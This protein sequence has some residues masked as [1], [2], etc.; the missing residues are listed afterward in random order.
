M[1]QISLPGYDLRAGKPLPVIRLLPTVADP[2]GIEILD[3]DPQLTPAIYKELTR[4]LAWAIG[5]TYKRAYHSKKGAV[6][7]FAWELT[8]RIVTMHGMPEH[9]R[10]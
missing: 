6:P 4:K 5:S 8:K 9:I 2:L 10:K 7:D 1:A 3:A